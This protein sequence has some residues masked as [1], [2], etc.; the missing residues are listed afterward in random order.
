MNK[1]THCHKSIVLYLL[2]IIVWI[3]QAMASSVIHVWTFIHRLTLYC[4][5]TFCSI[6]DVDLFE[7]PGMRIIVHPALWNPHLIQITLRMTLMTSILADQMVKCF[8]YFVLTYSIWL[9]CKRWSCLFGFYPVLNMN[10]VH[11]VL[12]LEKGERSEWYRKNSTAI[13]YVNHISF[14]NWIN[15]LKTWN[16]FSSS[17][18]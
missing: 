9:F 3:M 14:S 16:R 8:A 5:N 6:T 10:S 2:E 13:N 15:L 18:I 11:G 1:T 12:F 4:V 7:L 17:M